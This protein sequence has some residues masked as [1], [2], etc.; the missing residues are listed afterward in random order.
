MT[1][2]RPLLEAIVSNV[3]EAITVVDAAGRFVFVSEDAAKLLGF[4]S[5]H[6][7]MQA[8]PRSVRER[9]QIVDELGQPLPLELLPTTKAFR[10]KPAQLVLGWRLQGTGEL[11]WSDTRSVP[12]LGADGRVELVI[13]FFKDV[14]EQRQRDAQEKFLAAATVLFSESLD[15]DATLR[16]LAQM[17]VRELA[18]WAV[19][20]LVD[21][22]AGPSVQPRRVAIAH[23][24]PEK[25]K[26][27]HEI[28]QRWPTPWDPNATR[29]VAAV[30]RTGRPQ[31][32]PVI[33]REM[34]QAAAQEPAHLEALERIGMHSFLCVPLVSQ[35]QQVVG[36][37]S[38]LTAPPRRLQDRDVAFALELGRRA[39]TAIE[40]AR[41]FS[42]LEQANR[43]KDEFLA[44]LAHELR[45]PLAPMMLAL[46]LMRRPERVPGARQVLD[47][48]LK[49]LS[50][51]V[52]DLLD[53]SRISRGKIELRREVVDLA[54]LI[55]QVAEDHLDT[56]LEH[57]LQ[58]HVDCARGTYVEGDRARLQQVAGNLL[59]NAL[60]FTPHGGHVWLHVKRGDDGAVQLSVTDTGDGIDAAM[61]EHLFQPFVQARTGLDRKSGGLGLGLALVRRIVEL[62]GGNV[63]AISKG[64]GHGA[65]F[66][67]SLPA[68]EA[69]RAPRVGALTSSDDRRPGRRPLS[70]LVIDDNVDLAN[71]M[72]DLLAFEAENVTA[73]YSGITAVERIKQLKPDVVICDIGLPE[74]DGYEIAREVRADRSLDGVKLIALSGY[75]MDADKE[76]AAAAG[77]SH[78]VTK[79]VP[80]DQLVRLLDDA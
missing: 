50:R 63:K 61:R 13:N 66:V 79:P 62:H 77:F 25:V 5:S 28:R 24:D 43:H 9:Y 21:P 48:Q 52:D 8:E 56:F 68:A 33:P 47:R 4:E 46:E 23:V 69:P 76:R 26:L 11:R 31:L 55:A 73:D 67:V 36:A 45:N 74:K 1:E 42:A 59:G 2:L 71:T 19:V 37:L 80:P 7:L 65:T 35:R 53:V 75:G 41:L 17:A 16:K 20:E 72:R 60:K 15:T 30:I 34:L 6:A 22:E 57:G 58:L 64:K 51:L 44:M 54:A 14:T 29:G 18:D 10:G 12:V 70:V 27:A 39:G 38:L 32:I 3:N 78:H 40:N 49:H